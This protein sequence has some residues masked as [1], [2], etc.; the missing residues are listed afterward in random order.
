MVLSAQKGRCYINGATIHK[1]RFKER[2]VNEIMITIK[3]HGC[4]V[5]KACDRDTCMN[6]PIEKTCSDCAYF[7]HCERMYATKPY[8]AWC[9]FFPRRF[10]E[11]NV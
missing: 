9:D 7:T 3:K 5:D 10:K 4:C 11:N 8:N 2:M 6:L 1:T